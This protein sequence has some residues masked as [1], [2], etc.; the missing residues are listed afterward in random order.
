MTK[1]LLFLVLILSLTSGSRVLQILRLLSPECNYHGYIYKGQCFCQPNFD[2]V[3]CE[4]RSEKKKKIKIK[5]IF[6]LED[7]AG[8]QDTESICDDLTARLGYLTNISPENYANEDDEFPRLSGNSIGDGNAAYGDKG[9]KWISKYRF[10]PQ[11]YFFFRDARPFKR[12]G[13]I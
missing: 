10:N 13:K 7:K 3:K 6:F 9:N 5:L 11:K 1:L 12:W 8:Y 2:G 4:N